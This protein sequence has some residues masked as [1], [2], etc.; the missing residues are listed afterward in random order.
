[1]SLLVLVWVLVTGE[2]ADRPRAVE[3]NGRIHGTVTL[4]DGTQH[5]GL[6]RWGEDEAYW[7]DHFNGN[8]H[9]TPYQKYRKGSD[10]ERRPPGLLDF[11]AK[12]GFSVGRGRQ[13]IARFGD[14]ASI[15]T[16]TPGSVDLRMKNGK[17]YG[18]D[19]AGDIGETLRMFDGHQT[20]EVE[21]EAI[22]RIDF[23]GAPARLRD[24]GRL[25]AR[26]ET[27]HGS[28]EGPV[29]WNREQRRPEDSLT[30]FPAESDERFTVRFS[31]ILGIAKV[32]R[33]SARID[34]RDGSSKVLERTRDVS[35]RNLGIEIED[36]RYGRVII[37]WRH[38]ASIRFETRE[39]NGFGYEAYH[40]TSLLHGKVW[41]KDGKMYL[42]RIIYDLDES[43]RWEMLDGEIRGI[44]YSIPFGYVDT[45]TPLSKRRTRVKLTTG[46]ELVFRNTVDV[47]AG[48]GGL[49]IYEYNAN[50]PVYLR[51]P[52][53]SEV[54]FNNLGE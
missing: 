48:N 6:I 12:R 38:F 5:T 24:G 49:L 43:E 39:G 2:G 34:L 21:W 31:E 22:V 28:F 3:T 35:S 8:K 30:G 33:R 16:K 25:F 41:D 51:F 50:P 42:G 29:A 13:L 23:S 46:S 27:K 40:K 9:E 26:V 53:I 17:I 37:P 19:G 52:E 54:V 45:M 11:L 1:M 14:I 18:V 47:N 10:E 15:E 4:T 20:R 36:A 32:D 7:D 44:R